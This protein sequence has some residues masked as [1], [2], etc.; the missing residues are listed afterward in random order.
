MTEQKLERNPRIVQRAVWLW[1]KLLENPKYDNLGN[2]GTPQEKETMGVA[3]MMADMIPKNNT[4]DVLDRFC[5]AL[6]QK[7]MDNHNPWLCT[8]VDYGPDGI[9]QDAAK[10]AGLDMQFPWKTNVWVQEDFVT[11]SAGYGAPH[12]NQ[13]P[14]SDS[15]WLIT[16]LRGDDMPKVIEAIESGIDLGLRIE[17]ENEHFAASFATGAAGGG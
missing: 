11:V 8:S 2:T 13:Y 7:I 12:M 4:S 1:R 17:R 10:E 6:F 3:S 14:L 16:D 9:L 5:A 15:R